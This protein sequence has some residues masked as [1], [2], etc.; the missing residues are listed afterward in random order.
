MD[1]VGTEPRVLLADKGYDADCVRE[2]MESVKIWK[3]GAA[4]P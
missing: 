2:D 3:G 1:E 4:M